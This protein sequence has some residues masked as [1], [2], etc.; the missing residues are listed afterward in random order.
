MLTVPQCCWVGKPVEV[1]IVRLSRPLRSLSRLLAPLQAWECR[2]KKASPGPAQVFA[3]E[4][5]TDPG[6]RQPLAYFARHAA[7]PERVHDEIARVCQH[8]DEELRQLG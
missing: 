6:S 2:R 4:L 1:A 8:P 7:T 3:L 5:D